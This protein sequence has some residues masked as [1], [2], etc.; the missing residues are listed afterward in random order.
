MNEKLNGK[1]LTIQTLFHFDGRH[2]EIIGSTSIN[3]G[4][5]LSFNSI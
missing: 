3:S 4:T 2:A 1:E 5:L